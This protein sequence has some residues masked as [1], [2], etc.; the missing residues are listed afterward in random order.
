VTAGSK[1][2]PHELD[3]INGQLRETN[4]VLALQVER[5]RLYQYIATFPTAFEA[6]NEDEVLRQLARFLTQDYGMGS[7]TWLYRV[8]DRLCEFFVA[9]PQGN[10]PPLAL[11][12]LSVG[13]GT[14]VGACA[15]N[16]R[17]VL[18]P[19]CA[20]HPQ[21]PR[22][23]GEPTTGS[24]VCAPVVCGDCTAV[25]WLW[26]EQNGRYGQDERDQLDTLC[27][28]AA[29]T[30]K[31]IRLV[32]REAWLAR[33]DDLTKLLNRPGFRDEVSDMK[34]VKN[35]DRGLLY[36]DLD[37]FHDI[38]TNHGHQTGDRVLKE[39]ALRLAQPFGEGALLS[40]YGGEEFLA[41]VQVDPGTL[42]QFG[43]G[44]VAAIRAFPVA[45]VPVTISVGATVWGTKEKFELAEARANASLHRAKRD[46]RDRAIVQ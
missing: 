38:N 37:N 6:E 45:G 35:R 12:R 40:R 43:D 29:S 34:L 46:G 11:R 39:I 18:V 23:P 22:S 25:V 15:F 4:R 7:V 28:V 21:Y 26:S 14:T 19:D 5:L 27:L 16:H 30:I 13:A 1:P 2:D 8:R 24:L 9:S 3:R 20:S 44:V 33:H 42:Q 17:T 41:V 32:Q 31:G 36:M 10:P